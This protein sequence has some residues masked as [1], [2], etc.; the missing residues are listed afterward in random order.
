MADPLKTDDDR[1][2]E[3]RR[4][5]ALRRALTMPP[6]KHKQASASGAAEKPVRA[7]RMRVHGTQKEAG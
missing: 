4:D 3:R 2:T 5:E 6:K 7:N 1:Q